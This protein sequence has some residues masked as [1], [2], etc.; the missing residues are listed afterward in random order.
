MNYEALMILAAETRNPRF[1]SDAWF[2]IVKTKQLS[3]II[4]I[5]KQY[6]DLISQSLKQ[7]P[8]CDDPLEV[9]PEELLFTILNSM[10]VIA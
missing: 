7:Y 6:Q 4:P 2:S 9:D 1:I 10:E 8:A 3:I 5:H